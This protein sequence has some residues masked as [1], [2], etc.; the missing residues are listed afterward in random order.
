MAIVTFENQQYEVESGES[1]LKGL[2]RHGVS[3]PSS[4]CSGICQTCLLLAVKGEIPAEAQ[5]GLKP[6]LQK[7][8]YF[9][10]CICKPEVNIEISLPGDEVR[11]RMPVRVVEK[12]FLNADVFRLRLVCEEPFEYFPGQFIH[13]YHPDGLVRSYSIASIPEDKI[14]EF[15]IRHLPDGQ[16]TTWLRNQVNIDDKLEIEGPLGDCFYLE[17]NEQQSL[18]MIGTGTGLAPLYGIIRDALRKGHQGPIHLYHGSHQLEG[19][20]LVEE[21]KNLTEQ[22]SNFHYTPCISGGVASGGYA[23]GRANEVA[24]KHHPD[25]KDWKVYLCGHPDMV[26]NTK[27]KAFLAGASLNDIYSDPYILSDRC[28][29]QSS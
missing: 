17:G 8:N 26:A 23:E 18:L 28:A 10:A 14:L 16:M 22:Y 7:Q 29:P 1:V 6:T 27:R 9:L 21:L 19:L 20:Y 5:K 12:E 24:L 11:H 13:M 4:C 2:Q 3:I 25:L 15:H